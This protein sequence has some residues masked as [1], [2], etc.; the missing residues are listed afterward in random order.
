MEWILP[1][2]NNLSLIEWIYKSRDVNPKNKLFFS[3]SVNDLHSPLLMHN[4]QEV[5]ETLMNFIGTD[6]KIFI[7]GDFD[8]DGVTATSIMWQF[9]YK[10]LGLKALPYI[11][12]RFTEGYG[13]SEDSINNILDQGAELIITVD[14]GV[15]DIELINKY[16]DKVQFIITDHHTLLPK[17]T[18]MEGSKLVGEYVISDKAKAVCHPKLNNYPFVELCG[19]AVS[20]KVCSA[21]NEIL[22][23]GINV[24]K[25]LDLV[26]IGTVCDIMPLIGENRTLL[27]LG[28]EQLRKTDNIGL[29]SLFEYLNII[30]RD[31]DSYHL[32][33]VI[34]PRINATGRL[35]NAM[36]AVRLLTTSNPDYARQMSSRLDSLNAERQQLTQ[37]FIDIAD[38]QIKEQSDDKLYFV[39]GEDWPEGIIGLIAGKLTEKYHRP[40]I[41]G[42]VNDQKVK[43]SARSIEEFHIANNLSKHSTLL[44]SHGGHAQAAG[45]SLELSNLQELIKQLKLNANKDLE[46]TELVK[47]LK[48]DGI[49]ILEEVSDETHTQLQALS[50][51]GM[52]NKKPIIAFLGITPDKIKVFGKENNHLKLF[53]LNGDREIEAISFNNTEYTTNIDFSKPLDVAGTIEKNEWN[54]KISFFIKIDNIRQT[55]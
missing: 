38:E 22:S 27:K 11:P 23:L 13:L 47:K 17:D 12:S 2:Q 46:G 39:Y 4:V 26:A 24:N 18:N 14:C 3:P 43:A 31:L 10:D 42:S 9:L 20:W 40:V 35:E 51:F 28:L 49:G 6:R 45:L 36:D 41:V 25:Y 5:A 53:F 21:V 16:S 19:A 32:G 15:K 33:F 29:K 34:G 1:E 48:I 30:P 54:G 52:A 8:V 55:Y 7:H 37:K 50:P 44:I